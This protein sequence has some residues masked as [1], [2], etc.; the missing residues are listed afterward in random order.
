MSDWEKLQEGIKKGF[1]LRNLYELAEL[2]R[3]LGPETETP[4][5]LFT[6]RGIFLDL[7]S[8]WEGT[9]L[10]VEKEKEV[11]SVL[12]D[13]MLKIIT[14]MEEGEPLEGVFVRLNELVGRYLN[15]A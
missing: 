2:C 3:K 11:S 8:K 4:L 12:M 10:E 13:P 1:Y 15:A 9:P 6:F 7:A 14:L 5:V